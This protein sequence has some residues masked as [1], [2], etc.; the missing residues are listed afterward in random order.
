MGTFLATVTVG[1]QS[2]FLEH[3]SEKEDLPIALL[4]SGI[5][6]VIA[7]WMYNFLQNRIP[8][9]LLA[10]LSLLM[11]AVIT[12]IMEFGEDLFQ[13]PNDIYFYGFTQIVPFSFIIYLI[14]W[15][16]FGRMFNLRQSKRLVGTVD[17]GAM[18]ASFTAFF[19]IPLFLSIKGVKTEMLYSI[20]LGSIS[21]F[22]IMFVYL[23]YRLLNKTR[24]FARERLEYKKVSV[25]GFFSNSYL[26]Y[27]SAFVILSMMAMNFVDYSFLNVTTAFPLFKDPIALAS[28]LS[29]FEMTIVIFGFLFQ[30]L[31]TDRIQK[32]Y[33]MRIS[34]LI[35]PL[36]IGLFTVVAV[37]VGFV[38]GYSPESDQ[39][40]VFFMII[41]I[42]KLAVRALK[43]SMDNPTFKLYL[44]PIEND[45]RIDVQT[46]IEGFVTAF[47]SLIAGGIIILITNTEFF[48]LILI[49]LLTL[50]L[51]VGWIYVVNRMNHS[52]KDTLQQA[53]TKGRSNSQTQRE[54]ALRTML[55]REIN[56]TV[57]EKVIYGL[58]L[59]ERLEP[60]L[61]ENS[62]IR[63]T[64]SPIPKVK[65]FAR[66]KILELGLQPLENP[67][68]ART[69]ARQASL[70]MEDSDSLGMSPEKLLKLSKS[71]KQ[72]DRMLV[73]KLLRR[74]I[75]PKTIF[76]LLELLRD[77]DLTVRKEALLTA[78]KVAR[79]ETLSI[80]IDLLG[81][82][83][84]SHLA[85]AALVACGEKILP[86]LEVAFHKSGQ[87]DMVMLR[88]VQVMGKIGGRHALQLLWRK[89]DYPDKRIV[90]EILYTLR[91]INHR[92][93]GKEV[94]EVQNL[95]ETEMGKT[96]WNLAA[97]YELGDETE[98]AFLREALKEEIAENYEQ[99]NIL[100]SILYDP[101]SVQ[102]VKL[103]LETGNPDNIAFAM[104]LLDLFIDQELKPKLFPLLDESPTP[105]KLRQLQVF[106]P[107]ESYNAYQVVN[108]IINR[109]Y[110]FNNRWTKAC[111][112]HATA[113]LDFRVNRG[114][115]AQMFNRDKLLQETAAW[116]IY[117]KD[118]SA[119]KAIVERLPAKDKKFLDSSIENNRL[120]DG[121]NDGFFLYIEMI[122]FIKQ[123]HS[124]RNISGLVLSDLADKIHYHDLKPGEMVLFDEENPI[125]IAAHGQV[126]ISSKDGDVIAELSRGDVYGDLFQEGN[127]YS[128]K[129]AVAR[130]RS[131]LFSIRQ[132][133]LYFVMA[134]HHELVQG[135]IRNVTE[136]KSNINTTIN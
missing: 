78:R 89:A 123:S 90:K 7:T 64:D 34:L 46:K 37:A 42:S 102:L 16:T 132:M 128:V 135:L 88:I 25:K 115:V 114:L 63:L 62:L 121:L 30:V 75:G 40:V 82:P 118:T 97:L 27:M 127:V 12:G 111:A 51:V 24:S 31:A 92:A 93:Q 10:S 66:H 108:Y 13:D 133:D 48:T 19:L 122:M 45:V 11:I 54:F 129:E 22:F 32:E 50:P 80:L 58:K 5:F 84:F 119:Y 8:F 101:Q 81:S 83:S 52:Y 110:N 41:A 103:N 109:D 3:F 104:E 100:L 74:Q 124:F 15:G 96:I 59:M 125:L 9:P 43:E 112:V 20:A 105:E 98:T 65:Q 87:N 17:L 130:E 70:D 85:S 49:S 39:F 94:R 2:L 67:S 21:L 99:I 47:A 55:E 6:G 69:L 44:L 79:P 72:K 53:L 38:F 29:Y 60:A 71:G 36:L 106:F 95:L 117:N 134:N 23:A 107:R 91:F 18:L 116:V 26:L 120:L 61:F 76:I 14:F 35:N 28:F 77:V 73:A 86:A 56:S 57:E 113:Y 1:S 126:R 33:G 131:V 136:K 4:Y 68:D